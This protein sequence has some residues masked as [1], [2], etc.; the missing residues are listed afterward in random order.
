M[1]QID[2]FTSE[3]FKGN[4]AAVVFMKSWLNDKLLQSVAQENNL[5][6]TAFL[7]PKN[8]GYEIYFIAWNVSIGEDLR[9]QYFSIKELFDHD[10]NFLAEK[11]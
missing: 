10:I 6:E 9:N 8:L 1:F 5:S 7:V 3:I 4:P 2:A 11:I